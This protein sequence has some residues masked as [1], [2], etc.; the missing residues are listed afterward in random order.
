[1]L[2]DSLFKMTREWKGKTVVL[3]ELYGDEAHAVNALTTNPRAEEQF[4]SLTSASVKCC[5][6]DEVEPD[7]PRS[8]NEMVYKVERL[9]APTTV[10]MTKVGEHGAP[11]ILG[12]AKTASKGEVH[13]RAYNLVGEKPAD[14]ATEVVTH[15]AG[16]CY[17]AEDK[18]TGS[19]A[20]YGKLLRESLALPSTSFEFVPIA[21]PMRFFR[22]LVN[23]A[24]DRDVVLDMQRYGYKPS[25]SYWI[26]NL[27][28]LLSDTKRRRCTIPQQY[29]DEE[30]L[31]QPLP[32]GV[33][34]LYKIEGV[35]MYTFGQFVRHRQGSFQVLSR[36]YT[37]SAKHAIT[38]NA[39][40]LNGVVQSIVNRIKE[41]LKSSDE[42]YEHLLGEQVK[43]EVARGVIPQ[44]ATTEFWW[45]P[46]TP[47]GLSNLLML[48]TSLKAQAEIR[49]VALMLRDVSCVRV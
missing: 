12:E 29:I 13:V 18:V 16:V 48:R 47:E 28:A 20:L 43:R 44:L 32:E 2:K 45:T 23:I 26:T 9:T 4:T 40:S 1:M 14:L 21:L 11:A 34:P 6:G 5:S 22:E 37:S 38:Y 33:L 49:E 42:L 10:T 7:T 17:K 24:W 35:T 25:P 46:S 41:H 3:G 31:N 39:A 19:K 15:I 8:E 27:R 36:R 30:I